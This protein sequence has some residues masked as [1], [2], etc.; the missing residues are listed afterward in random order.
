GTG[1]GLAVVYGIIK[2]HEGYIN[3]YSEPG[4]GATFRLYLPLIVAEALEEKIAAEEE[5]P[6]HGTE[7][8]LV[9]EDDE[10]VRTLAGTALTRFGYTVIEA[11]DGEEA[12]RKFRENQD[13][14][15][16]LLFDIIMP[17]MN[18]QEAYEAI[19]KIRPGV[20]TIFMSGYAPDVIREKAAPGNT[21]PLLAK[22]LSPKELLQKVR[23][24][25]DQ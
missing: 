20:K 14:I 22:P 16:L 1:L 11:V 17:K 23:E 24:V 18:G 9:A 19:N 10:S 5:A 25:L 12:V 2:Q 13:T 21:A 7:T 15:H 3:L 4:G 8:I 6:A